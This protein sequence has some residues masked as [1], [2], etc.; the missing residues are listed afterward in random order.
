M[1]RTYAWLVLVFCAVASC[2]LARADVI[3]LTNSE[4]QAVNA[5][6]TAGNSYVGSD[7]TVTIVGVCLNNPE[8]ML[9][10]TNQWQIFIQGIDGDASGTAA[11]AG[12]FFQS[13]IWASELARLNASGFRAGDLIRITGY[14][15]DSGGKSNIN[16]RH[17]AASEMNFT[18]E[19]IQAD[20]G[21]PTPKKTTIR[22][23]NTFDAT[24]ATGGESCQCVR[25]GLDHVAL[26]SGTWASNT[27][28]TIYDPNDST[29]TLTLRLCNVGFGTQAPNT[30][31]NIV[32]LGDQEATTDSTTDYQIWV[33]DVTGIEVPGDCNLDG[34]INASDLALLAS[35][36]NVTTSSGWSAGDFNEDGIVNSDDLALMAANW[37]YGP[38]GSDLTFAE[39]LSETSIP[40]P[41]TMT[42]LG[43]A[44]IALL[45]RKKQK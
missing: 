45:R 5:D 24:R 44:G 20:Y 27:K 19:I 16:E 25:T 30:W 7:Y 23:M 37:N 8:D 41:T 22:E 26:L 34:S 18:V 9:D 14:A 31:F 38:D 28:V 6:G 21:L 1:K 29:Q 11:W 17:S 4:L 39:A 43:L 13:S 12:S 32:G 10:P 2:S 3:S 42:L 40:E 35:D 15:M 36:W 33:T